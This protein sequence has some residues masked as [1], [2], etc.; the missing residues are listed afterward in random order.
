[1]IPHYNCL[2]QL[3][4]SLESIDEKGSVDV[5]VIDDGSHPEH[6]PDE[7][8]LREKKFRISQITC[9]TFEENRGIEHVL[10]DG[11]NY[12][13]ENRYEFVA[14][15]DCGDLCCPGR[16]EMQ[17]A[18]LDNHP[19]VYLVGSW[20]RFVNPTGDKSFEFRPPTQQRRIRRMMFMNNM[21][22]HPSVMFRTSAI[23][24]I[25]YYP[26]NRRNAE[27]FAY[28]FKFVK[29]YETANIDRFLLTCEIN[30]SGLS[31]SRRKLQLKNRMRIILDNF[32]P[33]P[34]FF[35]GL[36]RNLILYITPHELVQRI[37]CGLS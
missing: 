23:Q 5:L 10:N 14:R 31:Y 18:F 6:K 9:L 35:Y 28:F 21:F 26:T 2:D 1:L 13:L 7:N 27:D 32:E 34:W 22:A 24:D 3:Y 11:L 4:R 19:E 16:F 17:Q 25:G 37:K 36:L 33:S 29:R 30:P 15:L 20:A 8:L 12:A